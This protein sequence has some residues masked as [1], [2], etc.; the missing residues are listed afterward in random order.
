MKKI[1]SI[2]SIIILVII[3]IF[4]LKGSK[5][6]SNIT[7][8]NSNSESTETIATENEGVPEEDEILVENQKSFSVTYDGSAFNPKTLTIPLGASVLFTNESNNSMWIG[9]DNHPTHTLYPDSDIKKCWDE[10]NTSLIFDQCK[11]GESYTFTFTKEGVWGY[12]NHSN[13]RATG[14]IVVTQ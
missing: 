4:A 8:I 3:V 10:D 14:T 13:A 2:I 5:E 12:H 9:S 11:N 6:N 7:P 1:V